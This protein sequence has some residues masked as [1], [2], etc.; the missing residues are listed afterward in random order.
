MHALFPKTHTGLDDRISGIGDRVAEHRGRDACGFQGLEHA[1]DQAGGD[2][3]RV[4]D[5]ERAREAEGS[6]QLG[7]TGDRAGCNQHD[8]RGGDGSVHGH[9]GREAEEGREATP[10]T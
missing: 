3:D 5:D 1:A 4:G 6:Q 8:T 10:Q 7:G 9:G 2:H